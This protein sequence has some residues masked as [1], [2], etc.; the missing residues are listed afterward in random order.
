MRTDRCMPL[1]N[2]EEK[3][4]SVTELNKNILQLR[5]VECIKTSNKEGLLWKERPVHTDL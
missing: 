5:F 2:K 3:W 1:K 4:I